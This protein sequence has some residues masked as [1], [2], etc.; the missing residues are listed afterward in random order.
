MRKFN[1]KILALISAMMI[2]LGGLSGCSNKADENV[3]KE[4]TAV[5]SNEGT[6]DISNNTEAKNT[7]IDNLI[8]GSTMKVETANRTEY[9]FDVFSGTITQMALVSQNEDGSFSPLMAEYKTTDYTTWTFK[10]KEG[11]TWHDGTAVTSAD[12][13]F[14]L[15]YLDKQ[16]DGGYRSKYKDV[17]VVDESTIQLVLDA[18]NTRALSDLTTMRIIPK[19]IYEG[20]EEMAS[21]TEEQATIGCGP[22]K[23]V[24]FNANSG[25]IEFEAYE[26]YVG[27]KPNVAKVTVKLFD[28][29]DTMY[30]AL[31]N[32]EIDMVYTYAS[33]IDTA[34]V[35]DLKNS[36]NLTITSIKDTSN[37][38]VV[39]FNNNLA[40][41]NN[42]LIR[43]A[44]AKAIDYD[45]FRELFG[46]EFSVPS[47]AGFV[48]LGSIGYVK[49]EENK[50]DLGQ[51][52]KLLEEAGAKDNDGDG[53]VEY[54]GAPLEIE[55]L[56]RSDKP[57]YA[58]YA[59]LLQTNLKEAGIGL[60]LKNVEV[61]E[62][63]SI[64]EKEHTNQSMITKFTAFGMG[65]GAGMGSAYLDGRGTSNAQGQIM[66]EE[67]AKIVDKLKGSASEEEYLAAAKECQEYYAE[68]VPAIALYWDSYI[69][70][71]NS[72]LSGF[73][74]DGTFG[75]LNM[76]TWYSLE[77]AE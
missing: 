53:I 71:Y 58:R 4:N 21:A 8:V 55:L 61:A 7:T 25:V 62:F 27:G 52:K 3:G 19:H 77:K 20:I 1:K 2:L 74:T 70:A 38:A 42:V 60:T 46:S 41:G 43:K 14:T 45:K 32:E 18:P 15:E 12:V 44:V 48:P 37:T 34:A 68:N 66:D 16:N 73:A 6:T 47:T 54:E 76:N 35:E 24:R 69:Q 33:G 9:N 17:I 11:L 10:I 75:I 29:A 23:F 13:E 5:E 36:G 31:K 67:F 57:I 28:N 59:E 64:S 39:V 22:Y 49:T 26:N 65:M 72:K 50:L 51:A 63:R 30:M 56:V 40:P